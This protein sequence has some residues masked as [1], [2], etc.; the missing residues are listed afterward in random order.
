MAPN[1][2]P[3]SRTWGWQSHD[4]QAEP[5]IIINSSPIMGYT[6]ELPQNVASRL[7]YYTLQDRA[8][9]CRMAEYSPK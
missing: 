4:L 7:T 2:Q 6:T 5:N 3:V 8:E 9:Y 1:V